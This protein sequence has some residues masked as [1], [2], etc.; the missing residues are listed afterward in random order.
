MGSLSNTED[1]I[2][3]VWNQREDI[4]GWRRERPRV[5]SGMTWKAFHDRCEDMLVKPAQMPS[6]EVRTRNV[7]NPA[8]KLVKS[9]STT[10]DQRKLLT[11]ALYERVL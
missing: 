1:L 3:G 10:A 5:D 4:V 6:I 11:R 2:R 9:R 7:N 8:E